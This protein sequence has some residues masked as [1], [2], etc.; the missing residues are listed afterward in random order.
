M[1][2]TLEPVRLS[3]P[4]EGSVKEKTNLILLSA[5]LLALCFLFLKDNVFHLPLPLVT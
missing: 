5:P 1:T 3:L 4:Q 2:S